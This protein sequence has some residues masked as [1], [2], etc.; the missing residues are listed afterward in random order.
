ML[1]VPFLAGVALSGPGWVQLPL[2]VAWLGG[3]GLSYFAMLAVKTG[4][5]GKVRAQLVGFGT[6]T[7]TAA[8]V[9]LLARPQLL[10]LGPAFLALLAVN[11]W[12]SRRRGD[13]AL[14]NGAVS[15]VGGSLGVPLAA[16][17][18]PQPRLDGAVWAAFVVLA[19]YFVGTV[20]FVK[21]MIRERGQARY[22]RLSVSWHVGAALLAG[23]LAGPLG[24]SPA[25]PLAGSPAWPLGVFFGWLAVRAAWLPRHRLGPGRVGIVELANSL[26]LLALVLMLAGHGV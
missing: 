17:A 5:P 15:A 8:A 13:R 16:L 10:L 14:L 23:L 25:W 20:F 21:T 1:G 11:A 24:G 3:Y 2:L 7:V 9:A 19:L 12:H 26:V 22:L 4:R 6:V 18:A